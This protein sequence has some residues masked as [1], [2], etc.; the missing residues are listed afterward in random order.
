MPSQGLGMGRWRVDQEALL[1]ASGTA[2]RA[3][4]GGTAPD[5]C[6]ARG[7]GASKVVGAGRGPGSGGAV[8]LV[9]CGASDSPSARPATA[10]ATA[11]PATRPA[12]TMIAAC[13]RARAL[14]RGRVRRCRAA[15]SIPPSS[16]R[17]AHRQVM[18]WSN[19][20]QMIAG[21]IGF[22][23]ADPR[24]VSWPDCPSDCA[25][26]AGHLGL[27]TGVLGPTRTWLSSVMRLL[28]SGRPRR[29]RS[30]ERGSS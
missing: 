25:R 21:G 20:G 16:C 15:L 6:V 14:R 3:G 30:C 5:R 4:L 18:G 13:S 28:V 19:P 23:L 26:C 8:V 2:V 22:R 7:C 24:E 9:G 29:T 17:V 12:P 11:L 1:V 27:R 10:P